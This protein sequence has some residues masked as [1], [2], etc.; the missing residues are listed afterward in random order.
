MHFECDAIDSI[1]LHQNK[2]P[3]FKINY[4]KKSFSSSKDYGRATERWKTIHGI[5]QVKQ[6]HGFN[7]AGRAWVSDSIDTRRQSQKLLFNNITFEGHRDDIVIS[8]WIFHPGECNIIAL[9]KGNCES[10]RVENR[11][12]V[13]ARPRGFY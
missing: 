6:T 13:F 7:K 1:R 12:V 11:Y 3:V 4:T 9:Q 2:L 5:T 8:A 10:R